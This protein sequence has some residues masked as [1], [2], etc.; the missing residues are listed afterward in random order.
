MV[1]SAPAPGVG[2]SKRPASCMQDDVSDWDNE[3]PMG[4]SVRSSINIPYAH[5]AMIYLDNMG[6]LKVM[7]S[8]SIQ[9]Q[10]ETVFTTEVRE[11]FLE[12]LGA[13]GC[14]LP[15][16][17]HT[18]MILNNRLATYLT[19]KLSAAGILQPTLLDMVR[20]E[21]SDTPKVLEYYERSLKHFRQFNCRQILKTFIKFIEPRK[22]AKHPYNGG[23][24]PAGAPPSKRGDPEKTKPKWWPADVVHKEPDHLRKDQRLSLLIHIIRKLGRFSITT[25]QLQEI[26]HDCKQQL[27]GPHKLQI[28]DKV[29]RVR[30]I[31]EPYERGEVD[32]NKI[33]YVVNRESNQKE[34]DGDSNVDL[35]QKH[36][37]EDDNADEALPILQSEMNSTSLMSSSVEHTGMAAPSH[38]MN[39]GD[40]R[41]KLFPLPEWPSF[42]ETPRD[43]R[44]FFPT[45]S[46]YTED[47]ASQ[48][49]PRTPATTARVNPNE[50]HAAFDYMTQESITSSA[51]EQISYHYQAPLPMQHS[52]S[53][54]PWTPMFR[55]NFYNPMVYSTAPS[56]AMSQAT[57]SYQP[58]R[59]PT[60]HPEEM[61][62]MAHSLP[63]LPQDRPSTMDGMSMGGP[64]FRTGSLSHPYDPSQPA[65]S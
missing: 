11:R 53:F 16:L 61:P 25:D 35:D 34:K 4:L 9:E 64:S 54:I 3:P 31:E 58:P 40:D 15:V 63:N 29:F 59:S 22:Q 6:R 38:P 33:V 65:P 10:N 47:Y 18:A 51:L 2:S 1:F 14:Q 37:Q 7:E 60:S 41:N 39:M 26:A 55:H 62:R 28:L 45:T 21:I 50:T 5:Y 49:M 19:V 44:T 23:K 32:A 12:I 30:R 56:H 48:Q 46:K 13:K 24:P 42:G 17:H 57:I 20:L 27:S 43:G 36:E 52:A 8:P